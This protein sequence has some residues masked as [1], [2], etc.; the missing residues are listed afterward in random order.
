MEADNLD[1]ALTAA[2]RAPVVDA[3][4]DEQVWARIRADEAAALA[5]RRTWLGTPW[6]LDALNVFAVAFTAI[7]V[8]VA[9]TSTAPK[10]LWGSAAS[11][12]AEHATGSTLLV[13]LAIATGLWLA[14]IPRP[15]GTWL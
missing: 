2:I 12:F 7:A 1:S 5:V 14:R 8:T 6:W 9:L 15:N 11:T 4:F 3:R 13:L 10:P